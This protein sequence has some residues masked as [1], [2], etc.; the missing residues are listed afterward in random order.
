MSDDKLND[1]NVPEN[2]KYLF[3]P[4]ILDSPRQITETKAGHIIVGSKKAMKL[5]L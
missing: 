4:K 2:S 5:S 3:L 1:L